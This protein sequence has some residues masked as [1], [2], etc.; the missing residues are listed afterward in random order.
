MLESS[1]DNLRFNDAPLPY[2][3][4]THCLVAS[5]SVDTI[6]DVE[7]EVFIDDDVEDDGERIVAT[8]EDVTEFSEQITE[9]HVQSQIEN[10]IEPRVDLE[11]VRHKRQLLKEFYFSIF[12]WFI[13]Y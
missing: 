3:E 9:S 8:D 5:D 7:D 2:D 4:V 11:E 1:L 6:N 13:N 10:I 12:P